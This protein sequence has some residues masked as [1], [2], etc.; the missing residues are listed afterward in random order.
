MNE[1]MLFNN[2]EFGEIRTLLIDGQPWFV[3]KDVALALGYSK[4][5][6]AIASHVDEDDTLK[7]GIIDKLGRNQQTILI[8]ESGLYSLI[9]SSKL[10]T[11]KKFKRWV[12]SEVLP[13]IRK[14]GSYTMPQDQY[15]ELFGQINKIQNKIESNNRYMFNKI[16]D[17]NNQINEVN[18]TLNKMDTK[19]NYDL[20]N[21]I[22]DLQ[23][24]CNRLT[25]YSNLLCNDLSSNED[26]N[27]H[28]INKFNEL[29]EILPRND[30][31][32]TRIYTIN[33]IIEEARSCGKNIDIDNMLFTLQI[34]G[35]V[36]KDT[37]TGYY[38]ITDSNCIVSIYPILVFKD[39]NSY[40][41][42]KNIL[43]GKP[44]NVLIYTNEEDKYIY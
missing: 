38:K 31:L 33:D 8:N 21:D 20:K 41:K 13:S 25:N 14:T 10:P 4:P 42:V 1:L 5:Q 27:I 30:Y 3:G 18:N 7:Q 36:S 15:Q 28:M 35:L 37:M 32:H 2:E 17:M 24:D 12:T 26:I 43:L 39:F 23:S 29:S 11:A 22:Q 34:H 6:N 16:S 40:I 44:K 9:L 19:I